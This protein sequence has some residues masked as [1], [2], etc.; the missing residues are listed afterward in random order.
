VAH[1]KKGRWI[2]LFLL[3]FC[4]RA[5][6]VC[7]Q[8]VEDSTRVFVPEGKSPTGA[9]IRSALIPGWGQWYNGQKLKA[10]LVVGVELGLVGEAIYYNQLA[11]KSSTVW[12]R[13]FYEDWRSRFLWWLLAA[14]ILNMLDAYVDAHL[15]D[16]DTGPN[17][18]IRRGVGDG[19]GA[20]IT[21][22]WGF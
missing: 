7:A 16:F 1:P 21:F 15:K 9:V 17:L 20:M 3:L 12:E 2:P 14:H 18:S 6:D 13:D 5:A 4:L 10:L 19:M 11:A 22:R 8:G